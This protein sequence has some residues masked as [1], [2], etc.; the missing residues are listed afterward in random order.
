[1][2]DLLAHA[3]IAGPPAWRP[4]LDPL[5]LHDHWYL[6]LVPLAVGI[7]VTY[8]GVRVP[9]PRRFWRPVAEFSFMIVAGMIAL[10]AAAYLFVEVFVA[11]FA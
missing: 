8:K 11:A 3:V 6:L 10:G 9:D 2:T 7:A 5:T 4:L 1:V